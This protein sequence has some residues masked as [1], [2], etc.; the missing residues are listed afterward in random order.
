MATTK[1]T[2]SKL[3]KGLIFLFVLL[4]VIP[5]TLFSFNKL[6]GLYNILFS[7]S[8]KEVLF[9]KEK[10]NNNMIKEAL[11]NEKELTVLYT[12]KL[13]IEDRVR[14]EAERYRVML[15]STVNKASALVDTN[16][17]VVVTKSIIEK[18]LRTFNI[19]K[20]KHTDDITTVEDL[21]KKISKNVIKVDEYTYRKQGSNN[22]KL[23]KHIGNTIKDTNE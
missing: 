9:E 7:S 11:K 13:S 14:E 2:M 5:L 21:N 17:T 23:I 1:T 6:S 8:N 10:M 16:D 4:I 18:G 12:K 19:I 22:Y 15:N 20:V 3:W